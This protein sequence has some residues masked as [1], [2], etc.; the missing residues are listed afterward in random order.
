[1]KLKR[2]VSGRQ[3]WAAQME[4]FVTIHDLGMRQTAHSVRI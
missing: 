2:A 1:M 4:I 3:L